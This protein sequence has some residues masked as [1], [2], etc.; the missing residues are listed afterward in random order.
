MTFNNM[1]VFE[2][3][4]GWLYGVSRKLLNLAYSRFEHKNL[5][6]ID[7]KIVGKRV[8][9]PSSSTLAICCIGSC[10]FEIYYL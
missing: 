8:R 10:T 9:L 2:N 6:V 1:D 5:I 3:H 7:W 4:H